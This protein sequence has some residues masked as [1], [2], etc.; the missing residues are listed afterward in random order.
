MTA[1]ANIIVKDDLVDVGGCQLY[2]S[3]IQGSEIL[4]VL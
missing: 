4:L 3:V 2:F 1:G